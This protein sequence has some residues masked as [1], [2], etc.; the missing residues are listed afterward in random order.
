MTNTLLYFKDIINKHQN[1]SLPDSMQ[2]CVARKRHFSSFTSNGVTSISKDIYTIDVDSIEVDGLDYVDSRKA[3]QVH[4]N[5]DSVD[6]RND[7]LNHTH[8]NGTASIMDDDNL[9]IIEYES[10]KTEDHS[11]I[12]RWAIISGILTFLV[13]AAVFV[14]FVIYSRNELLN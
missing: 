5:M 7:P 11:R 1:G 6:S 9:N 3:S 8:R 13:I 12:V 2:N 14:Y 4:I 10:L